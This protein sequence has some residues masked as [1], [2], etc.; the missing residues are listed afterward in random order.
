[1]NAH[2]VT[3]KAFRLKTCKKWGTPD[4][5]SKWFAHYQSQNLK[6][7]LLSGWGGGGEIPTFVHN[8]K[9]AKIPKS[10]LW[11]VGGG[12]GPA[13]TFDPEAK[14]VENP[15]S[16]FQGVGSHT[17]FWSW[18]QICWEPKLKI[19]EGRG[20]WTHFWSWLQICWG[21]KFPFKGRGQ[22]SISNFWSWVHI[23]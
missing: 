1:M 8:F 20:S 15:N 9:F 21:H 7:P 14:S 5:G 4:W 19:N 18:V 12:G 22:G 11:G 17:N 13:P 23:C 2:D 3:C 16:Y 6:S 10:H